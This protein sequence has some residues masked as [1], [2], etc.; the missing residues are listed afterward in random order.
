MHNFL[1]INVNW[2]PTATKANIPTY[3]LGSFSNDD[4]FLLIDD[5]HPRSTFES[6][7][8]WGVEGTSTP[9]ISTDELI[10]YIIENAVRYT[11]AEI[12]AGRQEPQSIWYV[13]PPEEE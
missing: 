10:D 13:S 2:I 7:L 3:H 9:A 6:W 1:A 11:K 4:K 5:A 8:Q 12:I